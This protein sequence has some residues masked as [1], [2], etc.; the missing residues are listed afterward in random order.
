[1]PKPKI[2]VLIVDDSAIVRKIVSEVL[3]KDPEIEVV[4]TAVD[5]YIARDKILSL[6]PDV[7]TLDIEMPRMDGLTFLKIIMKHHPM[8]VIIMSSLTQTGSTHV[9]EAL[10]NGAVEVLAKPSG[11]YSVGE[12][13]DQLVQKVKAAAASKLRRKT[14]AAPAITAQTP[15][16]T[17]SPRSVFSTVTM[18]TSAQQPAAQLSAVAKLNPKPK[19]ASTGPITG[20]HPKQIILLGASTGGTEALKDVLVQFPREVPGICIVQHIPAYF[21]KAFADRLHSLCKI[22]VREAVDGDK[23]EPGLALVAPGNYHMLLKWSGSGYTVHLKQGPPVW[24]QRPAVDVL[25]NTAA[26][27]VGNNAVG[28]VLTGMGKDGAEGLLKLKQNGCRTFAQDEQSCVVFGMPRACMEL[29]AAERM[30]PLAQMPN[31]LLDAV[32]VRR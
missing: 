3:S 7:L 8:P 21:S 25:F 4:G 30:V 27:C 20:F 32:G 29:G 19:S 6:D 26:E 2:K 23:V 16:A 9:M 14:V 31:V 22:D 12:L 5:P 17:Q 1:M 10:Q 15:A 13:A 24:H 28:A 18:P 11:A